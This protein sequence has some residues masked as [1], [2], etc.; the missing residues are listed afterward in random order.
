MEYIGHF[1]VGVVFLFS[2]VVFGWAAGVFS[3][4]RYTDDEAK[5][6][7]LSFGL[8]LGVISLL[9]LLLGLAGWEVILYG[10]Y[11][12]WETAPESFVN[13]PI[14]VIVPFTSLVIGSLLYG[15]WVFIQAK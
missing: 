13:P 5:D 11:G 2:T 7:G 12:G 4:K 3:Y 14:A 1:T 9:F 8:L 15:V 6:V 10:Y